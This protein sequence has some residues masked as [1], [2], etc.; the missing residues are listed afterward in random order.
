MVAVSPERQAAI[1][2]LAVAIDH[3]QSLKSALTFKPNPFIPHD[4]SPKQRAFLMLPHVE[5]FYGGAAG[6][7]KSD[8]LLMGAL[9]Y[10]DVPKYSAIIFRKTLADANQEGA[11]LNRCEEWLSDFVSAKI[12]KRVGSKFIFPSGAALQFGYMSDWLDRYNYQGAEFQYIA[13]DELTQFVEEDY[14]YLAS[15]LRKT[16][17]PKHSGRVVDG[18]ASPLPTD[19]KCKFCK[20][21]SCLDR[22]PLRMRAAANP[23]GLGHLWVKRR[24][25]IKP[26]LDTSTTP[27]TVRRWDSGHIMFTGHARTRPFVPALLTDNPFLNQAAY[28]KQLQNLDPV[29]REQLLHG[30]WSVSSDGR[31]KK[32]WVKRYSWNGP[33]I[34]ILGPERKG[35]A[36]DI[37]NGRNIPLKFSVIDPA[38]SMRAAPA[39]QQIYRGMPSRTVMGTFLLFPSGD[40]VVLDF[41]MGLLDLDE[42]YA[43]AKKVWKT[44]QPSFISMELTAMSAHLYQMFDRVG[45]PMKAVR[46]GTF[47]KIQR[48]IPAILRMEAGKIWFPEDAPWLEDVESEIFTWTGNPLERDDVVDVLSYAAHET[49]ENSFYVDDDTIRPDM[50]PF[51]MDELTPDSIF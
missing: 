4:P 27:P 2:A 45:L 33:N 43:M 44:H 24:W 38:A 17:C 21:F 9:Q 50:S 26:A 49:V 36:Y 47:D 20:E 1:D 37:V 25:N 8:A 41:R 22:V 3:N 30:D 29:T 10:V 42:I 14:L 34:L 35:K 23:G 11:I 39:G 16:G 5:A 40:L 6:G 7:G 18:I 31:F 51:A 13:F 28:R 19:P 12:V 46:P 15:R 32:S 48:S